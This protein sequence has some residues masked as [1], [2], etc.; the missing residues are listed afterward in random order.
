MAKKTPFDV[1]KVH[2]S[3]IRDLA[4]NY[5]IPEDAPLPQNNGESIH[6]NLE[7]VKT[8]G[9]EEKVIRL[10]FTIELKAYEKGKKEASA[11]YVT[12]HLFKVENMDALISKSKDDLEVDA[13]LNNTLTGLAYSTVRGLL[14]Q[15]FTGTLFSNFIL[16]I[17][18]PADL[19]K[20]DS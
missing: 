19:G 9:L 10:I 13:A 11:T 12:E 14:R 4:F 1:S 8:I 2:Y 16:P 17:I 18:R 6:F 7:I 15:K 3:H 20:T 5:L